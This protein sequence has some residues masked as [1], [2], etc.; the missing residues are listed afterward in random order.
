MARKS[1]KPPTK[2]AKAADR[3]TPEQTRISQWGAGFGTMPY[4]GW[5]V[6]ALAGAIDK[7]NAGDQSMSARLWED[8]CAHPWIRDALRK[9]Q[10]VFTTCPV[11]FTPAGRTE[12][13]RRVNQRCRDFVREVHGEVLP[14]ALYKDVMRQELGLGAA[15]FAMDWEL[16]TD[17]RDRW[18]L[19]KVKPWEPSLLAYRQLMDDRSTDGGAYV[20]TTMSHGVVRVDHGLG[21]WGLVARRTGRAYLD[22]LVRVLGDSFVGDGYNFRDNQSHQ[23]RYGRGI[24][25]VKFPSEM[26]QE[27]VNQCASS[28]IDGGG[29]GVF[30]APQWQDSRGVEADILRADGA[31]WQ[32]F[33]ATEKRILRRILIA[34]L[35]EDMS[36]TGSTGIAEN[37]PRALNLWKIV[38]DD[39]ST[40]G[41]AECQTRWEQ[42]G[43]GRRAVPLW[44][45]RHGVFREAIWRWV[46]YYNFGAFEAAPYVW[47]DAT[48]PDDYEKR[49]DGES[50]RGQQRASALQSLSAAVKGL[51]EQQVPHDPDHLAAQCG[52]SLSEVGQPAPDPHEGVEP[53]TIPA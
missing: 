36:T 51:R 5:T 52:L 14:L 37:D 24:V 28:L 1:H 3:P 41:D 30:L 50:R 27:E 21:Y 7:H 19:P 20:A 6:S 46:A 2:S 15:A 39:A 43:S 33:D 4:F 9:R 22:G 35:G 34:V 13:E 31:G 38:Q 23:D 49:L 10:Q 53:A 32:T 11:Q 12:E 47:W 16:R 18:W 26:R 29:G 40:Y 44:R 8:M 45:P 48:P 25:Q 42:T 17:G